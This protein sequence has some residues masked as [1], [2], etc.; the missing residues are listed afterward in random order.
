M[1]GGR[2]PLARHTICSLCPA[3][4]ASLDSISTDS[5]GTE[6]KRR[7]GRQRID[8]ERFQLILFDLRCM[9]MV[10]VVDRDGSRR[11][12]LALQENIARRSARLN[13]GS[14]R[15][16]PIGFRDNFSFLL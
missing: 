7:L 13:G 9:S 4:S 1:A 12:L 11:E 5:G 6:T 10:M 15:G 8:S 3:L 14:L 16:K 2:A